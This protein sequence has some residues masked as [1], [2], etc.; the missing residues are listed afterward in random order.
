[1]RIRAFV[2]GAAAAAL[3][4]APPAR[5]S[6]DDGVYGRFDGD[7]ELRGHAGVAFAA[8]GPAL[9]ASA[10]LVYLATAGVYAHYTDALGL[11]APR[12]ARSIAAGVHLQP[13]FLARYASNQE[14]GPAR[15]DLLLD[16]L[17]FEIG[18]VWAAPRGMPLDSHAGL[19]LAIDLGFP[20]LP[21]ATGPFLGLRG[22][23]RWRASD[24]IAG[25]PGGVVDRGA[26]LSLTLGWHHVLRAHLVD[27]GD[28]RPE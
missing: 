18:A 27:A 24:F 19:E 11:S 13:F 23:L 6:A 10:G 5:A 21:R 17:A 26:L 22:A 1:V 15:W 25:V 14:R 9:A 20:F 28:R 8:G 16:S 12:V 2:A 7:L 4:C 3:C